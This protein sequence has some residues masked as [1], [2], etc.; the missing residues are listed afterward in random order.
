VIILIKVIIGTA[1]VV[2]LSLKELLNSQSRGKVMGIYFTIIG[3]SLAL[4]ILISMD[5]APASPYVKLMDLLKNIGIR[6]GK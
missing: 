5:K 3:I 4:G 2:M 6:E 1:I